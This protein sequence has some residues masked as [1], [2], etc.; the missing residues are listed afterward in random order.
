M[1]DLTMEFFYDDWHDPRWT[2]IVYANGA[3][4]FR[5][6]GHNWDGILE[7]LTHQVPGHLQDVL[8]VTW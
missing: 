4:S 2:V 1:A 5:I 8:S 3:E 7:D 6:Q